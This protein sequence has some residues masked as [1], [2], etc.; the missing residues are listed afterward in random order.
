MKRIAVI[1]LFLAGCATTP[2]SPPVIVAPVGPAASAEVEALSKQIIDLERAKAGADAALQAIAGQIDGAKTANTH[3]PAGPA[4]DL[5]AAFADAAAGSTPKPT[6][7]QRADNEAKINRGLNGELSAVVAELAGIKAKAEADAK[8]RKDADAKIAAQDAALVKLRADAKAEQEKNRKA[9]QTALDAKQAELNA[10]QKALKDNEI[11]LI[12][13]VCVGIGAFFLAVS[14]GAAVFF[15]WSGAWTAKNLGACAAG[16]VAS[17]AAFAM[18]RFLAHP[19]IPYVAGGLIV[20]IVAVIAVLFAKEHYDLNKA[21]S[22][23]E[24]TAKKLVSSVATFTQDL[25]ASDLPKET[26]EK[27]IAT[28]DAPMDTE[29]QDAIRLAAASANPIP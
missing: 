12:V 7:E 13:K 28:L 23:A 25:R 17:T 9:A 19:W 3:N 24:T 20:L 8:A 2:V 6:A 18:S 4:K 15:V 11:S 22:V 26:K 14:L 1:A 21:K 10:A 27:V 5:T 29:H 16:M